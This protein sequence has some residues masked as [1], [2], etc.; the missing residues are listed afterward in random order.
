MPS[1]LPSDAFAAH[2]AFAK[3]PSAYLQTVLAL[4][5]CRLFIFPG[6][7]STFDSSSEVV[8]SFII[9]YVPILMQPYLWWLLFQLWLAG[10]SSAR[11]HSILYHFVLLPHLSQYWI[12]ADQQSVHFLTMCS[13]LLFQ[14]DWFQMAMLYSCI[15]L[16]F[17]SIFSYFL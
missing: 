1:L 10:V 16:L 11:P 7:I 6:S 3:S 4:P 5:L 12:W 13:H 14:V 8:S 17:I 15:F 9:G 2:E